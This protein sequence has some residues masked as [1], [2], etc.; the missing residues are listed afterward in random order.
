MSCLPFLSVTVNTFPTQFLTSCLAFQY[1]RHT[2]FFLILLSFLHVYCIF[3][4]TEYLYLP[5][6][7][8]FQWITESVPKPQNSCQHILMNEGPCLTVFWTF[9]HICIFTFSSE[10]RQL[11]MLAVLYLS[12]RNPNYSGM[13]APAAGFWQ[14]L[15]K[16]GIKRQKKK[17][18]SCFC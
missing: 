17:S 6:E 18:F 11:S 13:L 9:G 14:R 2:L 8:A 1:H 7:R 12:A 5:P 15:S 4:I 16:D 10:Q 3:Q